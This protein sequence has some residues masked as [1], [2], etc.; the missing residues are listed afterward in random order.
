MP[1]SDCRK[2]VALIR[3]ATGK[4]TQ[5]QIRLSRLLGLSLP[6]RTPR[7]IADAKLRVVLAT[8]LVPSKWASTFVRPGAEVTASQLERIAELRT[9]KDRLS[10]L[11]TDSIEADSWIYHL[12]L[13]RR[14]EYLVRLNLEVG[15]LVQVAHGG[16]GEVLSFG[17]EGRVFFKG[18]RGFGAWPD[19]LEVLFRKSDQS[20]EAQ[21]CR[22]A[23]HN[24]AALRSANPSDWS[25]AKAQELRPYL[26][27][28]PIREDEIVQ[29]ELCIEGAADEGPIQ[30]FL[31]K[32]PHLLAS[33]MGGSERYCIPQPRLGGAYVPDFLLCYAD[34]MGAHWRLVELETPMSSITISSSNQPEER[35]RVGLAQIHD[36]RAWLRNNL[37]SATSSKS[38]NGLGLVDIRPQ[39]AGLLLVGR[40]D[41]A[42][43]NNNEVRQRIAE[44]DRIEIH[45]YD[46]LVERLRQLSQFHGPPAA[47]PYVFRRPESKDSDFDG[48]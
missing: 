11:P 30:K 21:E 2:I 5:L 8:D 16:T 15:D 23:A 36:W 45:T 32:K 43:H 14:L 41:T 10:H 25:E 20:P 4:M 6:L 9:V 40:R 28:A 48:F 19:R 1:H 12:R 44:T 29:L 37:A 47:N 26:A 33:L 39:E 42:G 46:W 18:G 17:E 3:Q 13:R 34:S 35:V 22:K 38:R 24:G 7:L 31:S 27:V